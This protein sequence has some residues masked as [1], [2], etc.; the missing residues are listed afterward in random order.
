MKK[1]RSYSVGKPSSEE[2]RFFKPTDEE[3]NLKLEDP[4]YPLIHKLK[5]NHRVYLRV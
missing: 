3:K 1:H 5:K 4:K 2:V